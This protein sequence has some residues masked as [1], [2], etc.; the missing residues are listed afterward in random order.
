MKLMNGQAQQSRED[1]ALMQKVGKTRIVIEQVN[2]QL[3][4]ATLFSNQNIRVDRIGLGDLIF[5]SSYLLANFRIGFIQGRDNKTTNAARHC[6]AKFRYYEGTD[7]GLIDV[8]KFVDS[9]GLESEITLWNDLRSKLSNT[10]LTATDILEL[11]LDEDYPSKLRKQHAADI[12]IHQSFY[13]M[14]LFEHI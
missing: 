10:H 13:N 8:G 5:R 3:K 1:T 4:G 6:K 11:V 2:R 7:Y 14:C 9:W 12:G